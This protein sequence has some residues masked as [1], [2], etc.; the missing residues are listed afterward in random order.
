MEFA[1]DDKIRAFRTEVRGFI[2]DA[3]SEE[4]IR[5]T[6][7]TTAVGPHSQEFR[8][9]MGRRGYLS[10]TWPAEYGGRGLPAIYNYVLVE[11]LSYARAPGLG[12]G[13]AIVGPTLIRHGTDWQK[14]KFLAD[15]QTG[16]LEF[17]LAFSEPEAGSDL[18]S[19]RLRVARDGDEFVLSGEK[20]FTSTA[21]ACKY[22]WLAGRTGSLDDRH[23]GISLLMVDVNLPGIEVRPLWTIAGGR[24]NEVFF[25]NVRVPIEY[26]VGEENRGWYY[27]AEGLDDERYAMIPVGQTVRQIEV[28]VNWARER[29][30]DGRRI[31]DDPVARGRIARLLCWVEVAKAHQARVMGLHMS[32]ATRTEVNVASA[33][34]KLTR[35]TTEQLLDSTALD[36]MAPHGHLRADEPRAEADGWLEEEFRASVVMTIAGGSSQMMRNVIAR[37]GLGLPV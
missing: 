34:S 30:I 12:N 8:R 19:L 18:A 32:G 17:A 3:L 24:T 5:E 10:L 1:L 37:R 7:F 29:N 6:E 20:R 9:Q 13:A 15:I 23:K 36:L 33:M 26:L 2:Q 31:A 11:E 22:L 21:H 28:L 25:D 35:T 16:D 14:E 27:V 4:V